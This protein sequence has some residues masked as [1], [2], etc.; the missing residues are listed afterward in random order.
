M[1]LVVEDKDGGCLMAAAALND[2]NDGRLQGSGKATGTIRKTQTQ[3]SNG[4]GSGSSGWGWKSMAATGS[5]SDRQQWQAVAV[6]VALA[7][8]V[9][10]GGYDDDGQLWR[11]R[12]KQWQQS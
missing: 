11:R 8:A 2:C 9:V 1:A 12:K 7:A 6:A 4:G 10:T 5:Y 3:Q